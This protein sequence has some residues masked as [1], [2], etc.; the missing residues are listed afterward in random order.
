MCDM[1][2]SPILVKSFV[3]IPDRTNYYL[4]HLKQLRNQ[5]FYGLYMSSLFAKYSEQNCWYFILPM[6][7]GLVERERERERDRMVCG[8]SLTGMRDFRLLTW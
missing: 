3:L 5:S 2:Q 1:C 4:V 6:S 7:C 8:P